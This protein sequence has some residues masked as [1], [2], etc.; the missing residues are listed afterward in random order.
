MTCSAFLL[1]VPLTGIA[2][3]SWLR[4]GR[5]GPDVNGVAADGWLIPFN[6]W[7]LDTL[8]NHFE[9]RSDSLIEAAGSMKG[10]RLEHHQR[11]RVR[12]VLSGTLE[13]FHRASELA[14]IPQ[15][16]SVLDVASAQHVP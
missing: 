12:E 4:G 3:L 11:W 2:L 10:D 9:Q 13:D 8:N 6:I 1:A 16:G 5:E 14:E 15:R 7:R